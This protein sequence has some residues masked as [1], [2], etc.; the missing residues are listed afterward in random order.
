MVTGIGGGVGQGILRNLRAM[1]IH[2]EIIGT[3]SSQIS[4]GNH[5][6]DFVYKVPLAYEDGYISAIKDILI[7]HNVQL[8]IPSTDYETYYLSKNQSQLPA[9][10]A[11]SPVEVTSFCLDKFKNFEIFKNADIPFAAS[12][13]PSHYNDNF[14]KI[15]VKPREGRGSRNIY[16][17]PPSVAAFGD[18]YVVQEYLDGPE[19][20][21]T[22]YVL[23]T[24]E[25]HGFI[26][27]EREL[28]H[29]CTT[30]CEVVTEHDEE[31]KCLLEKIISQ[32]TFLGSCN[33]QSRVTKNG[34][35]PFEINCRISGTNS[36]RSQL[37]FPD[38]QFTVQ[39]LF[40]GQKP[41]MPKIIKGSALR[42]MLDVIYPDIGLSE[43]SNCKDNFWIY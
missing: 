24:G 14:E 41:D 23:Q 10:L 43:I 6:C 11:V 37:G 21:T 5:L 33:I 19:L 38:V 15:V 42:I 20:T 8:V 12:F 35:T 30:R 25:L 27:M 40:L 3:N 36:I 29:G 22:F 34:V 2:T 1:N 18:D 7:K 17:D 9:K 32:F 16:F 13:L 39:E 26:T 31:I 4:A 28:E